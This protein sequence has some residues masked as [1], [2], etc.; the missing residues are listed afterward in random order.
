MLG[1][2]PDDIVN[3]PPKE[4]KKCNRPLALKRVKIKDGHAKIKM[5]CDKHEVYYR[6]EL[7][8][9]KEW[10]KD[11]VDLFFRCDKCAA[12]LKQFR[13]WRR[14]EIQQDGSDRELPNKTIIRL[15]VI[16]LE[17][18]PRT[19]KVHKTLFNEFVQAWQ[20]SK[21]KKKTAK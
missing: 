4:C 19:R 15:R 3:I 9:K 7:E 1:K 10:L 6:L 12:P 2:K 5:I 13:Y 8:Q 11:A 18:G 17:H 16:C 14:W 21:K 20:K